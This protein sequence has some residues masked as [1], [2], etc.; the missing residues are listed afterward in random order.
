MIQTFSFRT[1]A[2]DHTYHQTIY[3]VDI[4][5]AIAKWITKIEDLQN[6]VYS[7]S[8]ATV[9]A[10]KQQ[11]L[12]GRLI[13]NID[14]APYFLSYQMDDSYHVVYIDT[15]IKTSPDFIATLTYL[16][17][18]EG[19]RKNYAASGYR[20]HVKFDGRDELT[21]G[22]QLFIEKNKVFPG[23]TITAEIRI[24]AVRVFKNYLFP[25]L[26]FEAVEGRRVVAHGTIIEVLNP[27]LKRRSD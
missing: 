18:E 21:T 14:E 9:L 3:A 6:E 11:Y 1:K 7:F 24:V 4:S 22:E 19:G 10:I 17:T 13:V 15:V 20:P 26:H 5:S 25:C 12:N 2:K 27:E 16:T 23:E 8:P